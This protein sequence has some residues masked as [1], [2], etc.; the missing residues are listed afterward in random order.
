MERIGVEEERRWEQIRK[1]AFDTA[2]GLRMAVLREFINRFRAK[3]DAHN[4]ESMAE[5]VKCGV[6]MLMQQME[7][8]FL[9]GVLHRKLGAKNW[10]YWPTR[11]AE[12]EV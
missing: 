11:E 6:P 9:L 2:P 10:V 8:L 5:H 3:E 1:V 7:D 12:E 4:W